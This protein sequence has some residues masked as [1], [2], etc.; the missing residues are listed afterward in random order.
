[1]KLIWLWLDF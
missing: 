1:L